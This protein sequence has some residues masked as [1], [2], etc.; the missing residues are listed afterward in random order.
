MRIG[1]LYRMGSDIPE[2]TGRAVVALWKSGALVDVCPKAAD[3]D[4][5][6]GQFDRSPLAITTLDD[7]AN[8]AAYYRS[9]GLEYVPWVVPRG[10]DPAAEADLH[11]RIA[12]TAGAVLV[13]FEW[14]Y[15]GFFDR[16]EWPEALDYFQ[17]MRLYAP[18][19]TIIFCPDPRQLA[20][21]AAVGQSLYDF[22][23]IRPLIDAYS[24]QVYW[25]DFQSPWE[26]VLAQG[27]PLGMGMPVYPMLPAN[28]TAADL[29]AA[30]GWLADKGITR[31]YLFQRASLRPENLAVTVGLGTPELPPVAPTPPVEGV[32]PNGRRKAS[33]AEYDANVW[34]PLFAAYQALANG[35]DGQG[36]DEDAAAILALKTKNEQRHGV[37][38]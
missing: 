10:A 32:W 11:G 13:D 8:Q 3:G 27:V 24:P 23:A 17:R 34:S 1:M 38:R 20:W 28:A 16:G 7:V 19:A 29:A 14:R 4:A 21:G 36:D 30:L 18:E 12:R 15:A 2:Q 9:Q 22:S 31:S 35:G 5:L 33:T 25:T 37:T 26:G 6:E